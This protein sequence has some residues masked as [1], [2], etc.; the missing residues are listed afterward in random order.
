MSEELSQVY[1]L[2]RSVYDLSDKTTIGDE[3]TVQVIENV[4]NTLPTAFHMQSG[5]AVI[6]FGK[7]HQRLWNITLETLRKIVPADKFAS[8]EAKIRSF[9]NGHGTVL[10]FD[11]NATT[12]KMAAS[13]PA[14]KENFPIWALE[15]NG[16]LE[17]AVW[18]ALA[19]VG[20]GASLQ[21]YNPLIDEAVKKEWNLPK[22]YRLL[23]EMPFGKPNSMPEKKARLP[24]SEVVKVIGK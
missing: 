11:E 20:L 17:F 10:F 1:A 7:D 9:R 8:T 23:A 6:L 21:H 2:R 12:E 4:V 18:T 3:K 24:I 16:M 13:F 15:A 14:Y 22:S 5:R 19:Q